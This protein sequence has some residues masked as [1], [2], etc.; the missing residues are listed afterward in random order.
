MS[1]QK[2]KIFIS[3]SH[4]DAEWL[5]RVETQLKPLAFQNHL[6]VWADTR[7][8]IGEEWYQKIKQAMGSSTSGFVL[9]SEDSV[10]PLHFYPFQNVAP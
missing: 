10:S 8:N 4:D 9:S 6:T 1:N 7:I 3:Y 2:A 5:K